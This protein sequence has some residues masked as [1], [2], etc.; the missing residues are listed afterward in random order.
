MTLDGVFVP[1]KSNFTKR[2]TSLSSHEQFYVE[3]LELIYWLSNLLEIGSSFCTVMQSFEKC[4]FW[5]MISGMD[6]WD[7]SYFQ[8]RVEYFA[9]MPYIIHGPACE[10][11]HI[12]A[13][14]KPKKHSILIKQF[15]HLY[16]VLVP[17]SLQVWEWKEGWWVEGLFAELAR[18]SWNCMYFLPPLFGAIWGLSDLQNTFSQEFSGCVSLCRQTK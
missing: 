7:F 9:N 14:C 3:W 15:M 12:P 11:S 13:S 5:E 16:K 17:K 18:S 10:Y 2:K 6:A 8:E 1:Q 4:K